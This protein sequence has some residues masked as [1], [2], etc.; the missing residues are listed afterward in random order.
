MISSANSCNT[1]IQDIS[2]N[3]NSKGDFLI[4]IGEKCVLDLEELRTKLNHE[5]YQFVGLIVPGVIHGT[6]CF[7]DKVLIK[8]VEFAS[9]PHISEKL[10]ESNLE[11]P[12]DKFEGTQSLL[13]FIEGRSPYISQYLFNLYNK[14]PVN[15]NILGSGLSFLENGGQ[16]KGPIFTSEKVYENAAVLVSLK[17]RLN[18]GIK[19]GLKKSYGPL[20]ATKTLNNNIIELNW[21]P[22]MKTYKK[23]IEDIS[24]EEL[25]SMTF[26]KLFQKFPLGMNI[27]GGECIVRDTVNYTDTGALVCMAE[28]LEN[29]V[30]FIMQGDT[31][32]YLTAAENAAIEA[33]KNTTHVQ[34]DDIFLI[35][36]LCRY[37]I[38]KDA[39]SEELT[40]IGNVCRQYSDLPLEGIL[41]TGEISSKK[42]SLLDLYNET[43][44]VANFYK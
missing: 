7:K 21:E 24:G 16:Y 26:K 31:E 34:T 15:L 11:I 35:D 33:F 19:H 8:Q 4:Y 27:E 20:V 9:E 25:N 28:I 2:E 5:S 37:N 29:S 30:L 44:I 1:L 22:A 13:V 39:Y 12:H 10:D 14:L 18:L 32:D 40:R 41:S 42:R 23:Y 3:F 43:V 38:L 36:C 17:S 6:E